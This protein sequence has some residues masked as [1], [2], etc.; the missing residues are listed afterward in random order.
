[1]E[2]FTQKVQTRAESPEKLLEEGKNP[3]LGI[4]ELHKKGI[5]GAGV[6]VGIID[7]RISPTHSEFRDNIISNSEYYTPES[8]DDTEVSMHGPAVVSLLVGKNCGVAP[9]AKVV[10]GN[11]NAATDGFL[12][13]I[14]SLKDIIEYNKHNEPK[15]KIVSVSK[16]YSYEEIPGLEEWIE[17]KKEAEKSGI[18]VVDVKYFDEN[19]IT[20]GGS[21]SDRDQFDG[22][23]PPLFYNDSHKKI[24]SVK[25]I[26]RVV[27]AL[28]E[29]QRRKFFDEFKTY[30][31]FIDKHTDRLNNAMIVPCDYRTMASAEGDNE[32]RYDT[33]GGLSW[34]IPYFSGVFALALQVNPNLTNDEFLRI[35]RKT[36][37][38][39]KK[40]IKIINP[41]GIIEEVRKTAGYEVR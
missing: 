4:R 34:A 33:E 26:E 38:Q 36:V 5:T 40:G 31:N 12:G 16:G 7:Q 11:I 15:I 25:D 28:D 19:F 30:Q 39:N 24:P 20:G 21:K 13:Y 32:Y 35:V 17:L 14:K 23:E 2:D 37:G 8:A 27:S 10:Y 18:T 41:K 1:M 6:V 9:G 29:S 3:G 22:Y